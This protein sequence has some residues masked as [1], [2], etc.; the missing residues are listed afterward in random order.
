MSRVTVSAGLTALA[1][2]CLAVVPASGDQ[3]QSGRNA[4]VKGNNAFAFDLYAKL[5]EK[6]GNLFFSPT[7]ISTAFGLASAGARGD[8]LAEMEKALHFDLEQDKLHPAFADLMKQ[9]NG[10]GRARKFQLT[11]ANALWGQKGFGFRPEYLTLTRNHYGAGLREVDFKGNTE[12]ARQTINRWVEQETKDKI[13][14]LVPEGALDDLTRLVLT[15]AI[16]FKA[17]WAHP[18]TESET[19]DGSFTLADGKKLD[20]VKL[21]HQKEDFPYLEGESFQMLSLPYEGH[22]LSMLI[23]LPK[24][25]DG[26]P[27]LEK[28]L[29][30]A[31]VDEWIGKLKSHEVDVTLPKFKFESAFKLNESLQALGMRRAFDPNAA[32]FSGMTEEGKLFLSSAL[33]K[34]FVDVHEKGT[35]AAAA[36]A[37]SFKLASAPIAKPKAVFRADRPFAFAIRE[38]ATGSVLFVGRVVDPQ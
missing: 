20:K 10:A 30:A 24:K 19:K 14:N 31:K 21:M 8:T 34:A 15:N 33:H 3:P 9:L 23:L 38:N 27:E 17:A 35:E 16:Y 26:L 32:D 29:T 6:D 28:S 12:G 4:V 36:T 37:L 2:C 25:A 5:R 11:V 18:F 22:E 7:S 1:A 13:K